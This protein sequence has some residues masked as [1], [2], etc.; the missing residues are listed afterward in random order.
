MTTSLMRSLSAL[1]PK[2]ALA[3]VLVEKAKR[4]K[5]R[6]AIESAGALAAQTR[7]QLT[8]GY[9]LVL[10]PNHVIYDLMHVKARNKVIWGGR[11]SSKSWGVAEALIRLSS[12]LP[13]RIL[14]VREFQ[15]SMKDS[16]HKLL[17]DTIARL[18]LSSWFDVTEATITSRAGAEFIFKGMH[19]ND[20]GI[21]STEGIDICWVEEAQTVSANSWR[22]L[23][24]TIRKPNG[25]FG[26]AEIWVTYN[27]VS[28]N[29]A[30]HQRFVNEDGSAKRRNSIVHKIN[31]DSNPF[32]PGSVLEEEMLEDRDGDQDVYEHVWLGMPQKRS[33]AIIFNGKYRVEE[34]ADTLWMQAERL[35]FGADFGF[36]D[37]PSTLVRSFILE[38]PPERSRAD[39]SNDR[40]LYI[41][42]AEY[43]Y[44]VELDDM[45]DFYDRVPLSRDWPI[46]ADSAR[47]ETI[48]HLARR[49]FII[50][51]AEKWPGSVED[52]IA[53]LRG[54]KQIII[55]TRCKKL[56]EEAYLYRYKVDPKAVD[57]KGQPLVLPVVIDKNN[58][59]FDALRYSLDG[60]IMRSG[61]IGMWAR[62]GRNK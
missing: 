17:K 4:T 23:S 8:S 22:S 29:D 28:E 16:S 10:D 61:E 43:G 52:G 53:H 6:Q 44:H 56:I 50:S 46:K 18:G 60:Y 49:G 62:L 51:A 3:L 30:T 36:A 19:N 48:S 55:H 57:A 38:Q 35:H 41:D 40:Y 2:Q 47:P 54:F 45:P 1:P 31:Y 34:F 42:Y 24:P 11:G 7:P 12:A 37:D 13:L 25:P 32:F 5:F 39:G 21:R 20:Q 26:P 15:N 58:H 27:L 9:S 14:C 33:N 59:G